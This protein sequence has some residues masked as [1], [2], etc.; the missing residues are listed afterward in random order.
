MVSVL[1]RL[2]VFEKVFVVFLLDTPEIILHEIF[3]MHVELF[4]SLCVES[5]SVEEGVAQDL[6]GKEDAL[7]EFDAHW[8]EKLKKEDDGVCA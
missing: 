2:H 7:G 1:Y 4:L 5:L 3:H 8:E 6:A